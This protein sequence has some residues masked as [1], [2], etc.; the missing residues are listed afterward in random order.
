M[1]QAL[2]VVRIEQEKVKQ[3]QRI[4]KKRDLSV[5]WLIRK[6]IDRL[7]KTTTNSPAQSPS[8]LSA[9]LTASQSACHSGPKRRAWQSV[10]S[11]KS[12]RRAPKALSHL[13]GA[14]LRNHSHQILSNALRSAWVGSARQRPLHSSSPLGTACA[15]SLKPRWSV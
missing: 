12:R 2:I 9:A 3:L 6:A 15:K 1:K 13:Y 11:V 14:N 4:A 8:R 7:L 5:S 10:V